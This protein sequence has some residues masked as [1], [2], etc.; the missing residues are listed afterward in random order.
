MQI[1][2]EQDSFKI[3]RISKRKATNKN[4]LLNGVLIQENDEGNY[5]EW[6]EVGGRETTATEKEDLIFANIICKH[7]KSNAI[8]IV[9]NKQLDRK[10]LRANMPY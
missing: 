2:K 9:K 1:K 7:L 4:S 10:R 3:K 6:K 5:A 8:A